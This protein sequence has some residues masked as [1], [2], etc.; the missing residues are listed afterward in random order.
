MFDNPRSNPV[1]V[2]FAAKQREF[3]AYIRDPVKNPAP[4]GAPAQRIAVYRE[5]FFNNINNFLAS[6]FPVIRTLLDDRQWVELVQDFYAQHVSKSPYFAKIPEEFI[7]FLQAERVAPDDLPFLLELAHYEWVEMAL[8]IATAE[9][10]VQVAPP[11]ALADRL[12]TLSPLAW[13]LAYEYPVHKIAPD[14]LPVQPPAS[15]TFLVVYR[16]VADDVHFFEVTP[17]TYR[18][19][20]M[21]ESLQPVLAEACLRRLCSE[22]APVDPA[23]FIDAGKSLLGELVEKGIIVVEEV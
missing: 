21:V 13:P 9:P 6:S 15:A 11:S 3:A 4:A 19:L 17:L 14:Y 2:G 10:V 5:L 22:S 7:A 16:D 8:S 20:T 12:I 23:A 18:L 1:P